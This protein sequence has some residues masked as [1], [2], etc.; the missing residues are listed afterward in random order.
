MTFFGIYVR[1]GN[2]LEGE[3][4]DHSEHVAPEADRSQLIQTKYIERLTRALNRE[5]K[6]ETSDF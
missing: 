6:R 2:N 1:A 4:G 3:G 5:R